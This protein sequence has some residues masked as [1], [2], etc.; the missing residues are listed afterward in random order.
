MHSCKLL[1]KS[2]ANTQHLMMMLV[3][4]ASATG[5]VG[6]ADAAVTSAALPPRS[7]SSSF[8][9]QPEHEG[10]SLA[11]DGAD[12][13]QQQQF[14]TTAVQ[15]DAAEGGTDQD[16]ANSPQEQDAAGGDTDST[17]SDAAS[18]A[19][20]VGNGAV[21]DTGAGAQDVLAAQQAEFEGE[22]RGDEVQPPG[23]P[24]QSD[25]AIP[26]GLPVHDEGAGPAAAAVADTEDA[27]E[28]QSLQPE[29]PS[30]GDVPPEQVAD[31][32]NDFSGHRH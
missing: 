27:R 26:E 32:Q 29:L 7:S 21:P 18:D 1:G 17:H 23:T 13:P 3:L 11:T 16:A 22:H 12:V 8:R 10:A 28:V 19:E 6:D 4:Q 30:S 2:V 20:A 25:L 31:G 9:V 5:G 15:G 24:A 14:Q